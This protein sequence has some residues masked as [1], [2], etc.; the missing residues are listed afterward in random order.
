[1]VGGSGE[2]DYTF[3]LGKAKL[4][5]TRWI[6]DDSGMKKHL[7]GRGG[8]KEGIKYGEKRNL[9]KGALSGVNGED[10]SLKVTCKKA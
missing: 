10:L 9:L 5:S 8:G 7:Q 6:L 3:I 1:M 4:K 2:K